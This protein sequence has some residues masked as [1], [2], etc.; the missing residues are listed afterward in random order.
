MNE[1][2]TLHKENGRYVLRFERFLPYTPEEVFSVLTNPDAFSQWYPFATGEI[3]L[4]IGGGI[5]FDDGEGTTYN[6]VITELEQPHVFGFREEDDLLNIVIRKED[7]GSR[8]IFTHTF[9][10]DA[11]AVETAAGWHVCLDAFH[12]LVYGQP[13]EWKNNAAELKEYYRE[14]LDRTR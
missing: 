9:D 6:G 8:M 4:R 10:D 7:T 1:Y 2:G 11:W 5:A 13:V 3:D 12:Q 14:T